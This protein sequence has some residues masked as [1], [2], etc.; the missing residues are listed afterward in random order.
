M[1]PVAS[2][3]APTHWWL[4]LETGRSHRRMEREALTL[5]RPWVEGTLLLPQAWPQ[6]PTCMRSRPTMKALPWQ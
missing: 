1:V 3:S 5:E 4:G 2:L 6:P